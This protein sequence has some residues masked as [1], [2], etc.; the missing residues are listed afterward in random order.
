VELSDSTDESSNDQS[1]IESAEVP[2]ASDG[3]EVSTDSVGES[4]IPVD[5]EAAAEEELS[6][7]T[8]AASNE[9]AGDASGNQ[10]LQGAAVESTDEES[11]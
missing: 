11:A 5:G 10:E 9:T 8:E 3:V 1:V 7:S 6:G 4:S 2:S